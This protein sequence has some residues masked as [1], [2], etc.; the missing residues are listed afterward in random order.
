MADQLTA[1]FETQP[2]GSPQSLTLLRYALLYL[3]P[4]AW[5]SSPLEGSIQQQMET[6]ADTHRKTLNRG[7][8]TL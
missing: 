7:Q 8:G 5:Y 4:G 1:H 6:D 3:H 2:M